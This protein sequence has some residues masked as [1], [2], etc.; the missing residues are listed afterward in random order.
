MT[1]SENSGVSPRDSTHFARNNSR[2]RWVLIIATLLILTIAGGLGYHWFKVKRAERFA[3]AGDSLLAANKLN[4][5]AVQ[6]RVALQ[7]DPSGY[8]GLSGAA[9]LASKADRPEAVELW[10][11]VL[12]LPQCTTRDREDYADLLIK[13]NR[14]SLAEKIIN[15]LLKQDP[16]TKALQLAARYSKKIGTNSK[17]I[18]Y[19]RIAS[20]RAPDD[21]VARLQLAELLAQS[22]EPADQA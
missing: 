7:L 22:I 10:Q 11:K 12:A 21:D 14:L 15:P 18:E 3:A 17:A 4:E 16:D 13:T 1:D 8:R 20:K 19:A 9:R 6:Y 2:K 5:A